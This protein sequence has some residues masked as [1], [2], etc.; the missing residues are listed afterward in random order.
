MGTLPTTSAKAIS[1]KPI[2]FFR[3]SMKRPKDTCKYNKEIVKIRNSFHNIDLK[4][5]IM[6][7]YIDSV[8]PKILTKNEISLVKGNKRDIEEEKKYLLQEITDELNNLVISCDGDFKINNKPNEVVR[9]HHTEHFK[10]IQSVNRD[11]P[12]LDE[13]LVQ[14][15]M[16]VEFKHSDFVE[17]PVEEIVKDDNQVE[18]INTF[19]NTEATTEDDLQSLLI[20]MALTPKSNR[21]NGNESLAETNRSDQNDQF[22]VKENAKSNFVHC[23]KPQPQEEIVMSMDNFLCINPMKIKI[24]TH[25]EAILR[26]YVDKWR[27]YVNK[28]NQYLKNQRQ[29]ALDNF[30]DKLTKKKQNIDQPP[31]A[32]KKTKI[33]TTDYTYQ[34]K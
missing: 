20:M 29:A 14:E 12:V 4:N 27:Q 21:S 5:R 16:R 3:K 24:S 11:S 33:M 31:A 10:R 19:N 13:V 28:K 30:F 22:R 25:K 7:K 32:N 34:R 6:L 2:F 26:K 15:V 1:L 8:K 23:T 18:E 9:Y 17:S